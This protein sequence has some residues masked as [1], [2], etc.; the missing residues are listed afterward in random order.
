MVGGEMR[1]AYLDGAH[2]G[3]P[4]IELAWLGPGMRAFYDSLPRASTGPPARVGRK[5]AWQAH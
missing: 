1:F 5:V 4:Y 3:V 2:V